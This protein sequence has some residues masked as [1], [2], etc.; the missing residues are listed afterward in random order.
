MKKINVLYFI[1]LFLSISLQ[2]MNNQKYS[3]TIFTPIPL[4]ELHQTN[5]STPFNYI[6]SI[7]EA[8]IP[9]ACCF[10]FAIKK[11]DLWTDII[12]NPLATS[13]II[14]AIT[15]YYLYVMMEKNHQKIDRDIINMIQHVFHL[16]IIGHGMFNKITKSSFEQNKVPSDVV[17]SNLNTLE[18]FLC[19]A[20]QTWSVLFSYY[21][22]RYKNKTVYAYNMNQMGIFEILQA[23]DQEPDILPF[24]ANF[25]DK[26]NMIFDYQPI[27]NCLEIKLKQINHR[28]KFLLPH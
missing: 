4:L 16:L 27:L 14:Y 20:Y 12:Q 8:S 23:A 17:V 26:K 11:N 5:T 19:N 25:Y 7:K 10:C 28:L 24:I 6:A 2:A 1:S 18:L 13:V 15:H 22:E 21:Q 9:I 3:T